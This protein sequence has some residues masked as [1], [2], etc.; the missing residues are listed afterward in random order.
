MFFQFSNLMNYK[1]MLISNFNQPAIKEY[2]TEKIKFLSNIDWIGLLMEL[3][4]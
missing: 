3:M 4:S 2:F 1:K